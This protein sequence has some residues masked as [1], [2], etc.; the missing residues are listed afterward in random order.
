M[1]NQPEILKHNAELTPHQGKLLALHP[2]DIFVEQKNPTGAWPVHEKSAAR[3]RFSRTGQAG[4]N[5]TTLT[6]AQG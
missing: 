2:A 3:A 6:P 4:K 1:V 5:E